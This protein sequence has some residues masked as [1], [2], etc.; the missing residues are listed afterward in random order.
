LRLAELDIDLAGLHAKRRSFARS[1]LDW[2]EREPHLAGALGAAL[3]SRFLELDW[4]R[5]QPKCR[6]V[7]LTPAG[8][9]GLAEVF[10]VQA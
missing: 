8:R 5:R 3:A 4:I 9:A 7:L 10:A 2:S 6:A 1:C